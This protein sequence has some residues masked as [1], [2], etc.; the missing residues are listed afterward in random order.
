MWL[1]DQLHHAALR[2]RVSLW[3][4]M[5]MA[6]GAGLSWTIAT[7]LLGHPYPFFAS[8][9]AVVCLGL[10][11]TKR[12]RRVA[13]LAAGVTV[14]VAIGELLAQVLGRGGWQI[15]L[16][17]GL[18]LLL[19]RLLDS[20]SL[21]ATQAAVQAVLV[22]AIPQQSG[23]SVARWEDAMIGGAVALVIALV[24]PQNPR[25]A[26]DEEARASVDAL[27]DVLDGAANAIRTRDGPGA[28]DALTRARATQGVLDRWDEAVT[29][30]EE[31]SRLS[32]LRRR[33]R[34]ELARHRRALIGVDRASRNAR[35]LVRRVSAALD[36]GREVPTEIADA[37]ERLAV[38]LAISGVRIASDPPPE[39]VAKLREVATG[40][41]VDRAG[42]G[43]WAGT[44]AIAQLRSIVVDLLTATGMPLREA[45]AMLP[46]P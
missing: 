1:G 19:A 30:G 18:S 14:G 24:T 28:E 40:L 31:I 46:A 25:P 9:A 8:V 6:V 41:V 20:G 29:T 23:Q 39:L 2:V 4:I 33:Q 44:V 15:G 21:I 38:I 27:V 37:L 11:S 43:T 32:P 17:V 22:L 16:V 3:S 36:D 34:D 5:Q 35:V 10:A 13:E 26:A 42:G 12:A 7:R 45:R